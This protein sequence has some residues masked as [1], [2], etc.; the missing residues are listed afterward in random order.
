MAPR[1]SL[2]NP[3]MVS[4]DCCSGWLSFDLSPVLCEVQEQLISV[5]SVS[6]GGSFVK[7]Y[8]VHV[9]LVQQT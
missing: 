9:H 6:H 5:L 7:F 1:R 3:C 2:L 4:A 8:P